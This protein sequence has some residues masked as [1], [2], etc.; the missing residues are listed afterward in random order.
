MITQIQS[1]S[2]WLRSLQTLAGQFE[3]GVHGDDLALAQFY[4]GVVRL[5]FWAAGQIAPNDQWAQPDSADNSR[6][7]NSRRVV[8]EILKNFIAQNPQTSG[9]ELIEFLSDL[10]GQGVQQ[11][12]SDREPQLFS[13]TADEPAAEFAP[14]AS[15][16]SC[17]QPAVC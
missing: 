10:I 8:R 2:S 15:D 11:L 4:E 14:N 7:K 5:T 12:R 16:H 3:D 13:K 6:R 17:A 9:R 1:D